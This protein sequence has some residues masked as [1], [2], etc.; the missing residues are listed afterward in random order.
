MKSLIFLIVMIMVTVFSCQS[1][2]FSQEKKKWIYDGEY[3]SVDDT[4]NNRNI[5]PAGSKFNLYYQ[6]IQILEGLKCIKVKLVYGKYISLLILAISDHGEVAMKYYKTIF[7]EQHD[8]VQDY[9]YYPNDALKWSIPKDGTLGQKVYVL[10][11]ERQ[12]IKN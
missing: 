11:N 8:N 4:T 1:K 3:F 5:V 6:D 10:F 12:E 7:S 2:V 9:Y